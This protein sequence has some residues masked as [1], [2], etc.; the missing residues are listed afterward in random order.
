MTNEEQVR[1]L[2]HL[3]GE[4]DN[5]VLSTYLYLATNIVLRKAYPYGEGTEELPA[6]YEST[7][8]EIAV[9]LLNKRGAEGEQAHT[10]NG[11]QRIYE[12]GDIPSTLLRRITP[13]VGVL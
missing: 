13:V 7:M 5:G 6:K 10:E 1:T 11:V 12:D 4:T 3:T 8:I 2:S 9:Y